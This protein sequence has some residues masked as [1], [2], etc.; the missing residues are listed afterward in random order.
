MSE[1]WFMM[2][3]LVTSSFLTH[4]LMVKTTEKSHY[5][6]TMKRIIQA[7]FFYVCITCFFFSLSK[8]FTFFFSQ[9]VIEVLS[10]LDTTYLIFK[11][12]TL[13]GLKP[14]FLI[15]FFPKSKTK[16]LFTL[17]KYYFFFI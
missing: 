17:N 2:E 1:I 9:T 12:S 11:A 10:K 13:M 5:S 4:G 8:Q 15:S 3:W 14:F 16:K 7:K 6:S